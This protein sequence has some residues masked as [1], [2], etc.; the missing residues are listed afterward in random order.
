MLLIA[1]KYACNKQDAKNYCQYYDTDQNAYYG[2]LNHCHAIVVLTGRRGLVRISRN[3]LRRLLILC[4]SL[5]RC[6]GLRRLLILNRCG[7]R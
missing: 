4:R 5:E 6:N 2:L 7:S 1:A 3:L